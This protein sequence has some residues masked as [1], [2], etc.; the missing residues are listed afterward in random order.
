MTILIAQQ[1]AP[2]DDGYE[3]VSGLDQQ[4]VQ[5]VR[6]CEAQAAAKTASDYEHVVWAYGVIWALFAGFGVLLW[7]RAQAQR[8]DLAELQ[9]RLARTKDA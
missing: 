9:R 5:C 6:A 7:R 8:A 4:T 3:P 1:M 2:A